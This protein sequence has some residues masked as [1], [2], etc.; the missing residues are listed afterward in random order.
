MDPHPRP[1][2]APLTKAR[3]EEELP[4]T[5]PHRGCKGEA[6]KGLDIQFV[7]QAQPRVLLGLQWVRGQHVWVGRQNQHHWD[8][9]PILE[10]TLLSTPA[11]KP[12]AHP[13]THEMERGMQ[14]LTERNTK[15]YINV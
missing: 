2:Q 15:L 8:R 10:L 3:S 1:H 7:H 12:C 9:Y 14:V 6:D 13:S 4:D 5:V 11:A